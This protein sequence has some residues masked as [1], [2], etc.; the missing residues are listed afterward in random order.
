VH[1]WSTSWADVLFNGSI[2]KK[3]KRDRNFVRYMGLGFGKRM[4]SFQL[5]REG[6]QSLAVVGKTWQARDIEICS[7]C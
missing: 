5:T 6:G 3:R 1:P 4:S 2:T 7:R